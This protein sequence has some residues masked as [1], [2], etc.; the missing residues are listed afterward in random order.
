[1]SHLQKLR[2]S[3]QANLKKLEESISN[4]FSNNSNQNDDRLW[5]PDA[6]DQGKGSATIRFLPAPDGEENYVRLFS[7]GFKGPGGWYIE[8]SLTTLGK[9]DPVGEWN[10]KLWAEGKDSPGQKRVSGSGK[11]SPGTKRK[12]NYFSNI[13]VV[14]DPL[15]PENNGTVRIFKYGVK[16]W[17]LIKAALHPEFEEQKKFDPFYI[18]ESSNL[19]IR[20][21][22]KG[23]RVYTNAW[24]MREEDGISY[25]RGPLFKDE[26]KMEALLGQVHSLTEFVSPDKFKTYNELKERLDLVLGRD[27]K[28]KEDDNR[29]SREE[30]EG[31]VEVEE[32][33]PPWSAGEASTSSEDEGDDA[34]FARIRSKA[35]R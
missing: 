13:Y 2:D 16:V 25:P 19:K 34:F 1:M 21:V 17:D 22:T 32:T 7:H 14:D 12:V 18:L 20:F 24:D 9:P 35:G 28:T 31:E 15:H 8:N 11:D 26:A 4:E 5:Y 30:M 33:S 27:V 6:D 23:Y 29:P 3:R 10:R